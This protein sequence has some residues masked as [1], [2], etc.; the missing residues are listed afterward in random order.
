MLESSAEFRLSSLLVELVVEFSA[1]VVVDPLSAVSDL[2]VLV[3][4]VVLL[5]ESR[6]FELS[7]E[8]LTDSL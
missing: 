6:L 8:L 2:L 5:V 4:E 1:V 7:G 3:S